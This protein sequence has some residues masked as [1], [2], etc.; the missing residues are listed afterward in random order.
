[1]EDVRPLALVVDDDEAVARFVE[2]V[3]KDEMR[4]RICGNGADALLLLRDRGDVDVVL[5]DINLPDIGGLDIL[6]EIK[7]SRPD[8]EVVMMTA[9]GTVETAVEAMRLGAYDFIPKSF[10]DPDLVRLRVRRALEQRSLARKARALDARLT[11]ES[12]FSEI[13]GQSSRMR[14]VFR[15]V[16]SVAPSPTTVLVEGESGTGKELVARAIHTRSPRRQRAFLAVNCAALQESLLE[17]E[18]FG[19]V[20]GA[21]TG[22]VKDKAGLFEA[23]SG[24]TLFLDEIGDMPTSLQVKLLRAL[25]EGEIRRV[26]SNQP[27]RVD[28]RIVAATNRDLMASIAKGSFRDDLY[29]RLAVISVRLP[30]LRERRDD[31]PLLVYYFLR[32]FSRKLDKEI[33]RVEP[34][35]L[36]VLLGYDW[37]GNVRE[38]ENVIER[39]MLLSPA[40]Q[41][42]AAS[43]PPA[44]LRRYA[45]PLPGEASREPEIPYHEAKAMATADFERRY[46][47]SALARAG[48]NISQAARLA[49]LD[50]SNFKKVMK[51]Y[52]IR[53]LG[54]QPEGPSGS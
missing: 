9:F 1:M 41:L 33:P 52:D 21:F 44:L 15:L 32:K 31:V 22:A 30:A 3:L 34:Q 25:Q 16:E 7:F 14:E 2:R 53:E 4:V 36:E 26:G 8:T 46:V 54:A 40:G 10:D 11:E 45:A 42:V 35:C 47:A 28:V 48:G 27:Q 6:K 5:L 50:R 20:K 13:V 23:A 37:P 51:R 49:G 29:Y 18:L 17:S 38:L 39:A 12:S 19:H 24:G 43:L